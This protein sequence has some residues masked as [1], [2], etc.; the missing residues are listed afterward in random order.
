MIFYFVI[1]LLFVFVVVVKKSV[2]KKLELMDDRIFELE[3][4]LVKEADPGTTPSAR[5]SDGGCD[6]TQRE[7]NEDEQSA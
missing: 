6:I 3:E 7:E 2:E 5:T 4:K 1:V